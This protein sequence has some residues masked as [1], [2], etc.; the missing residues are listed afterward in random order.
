MS[1]AERRRFQRIPFVT[2]VTLYHDKEH[3]PVELVDLSLKGAL[4]RVLGET[5]LS[6]GDS[7][8]LH[9]VLSSDVI[10]EMQG[11]IA[12]EEGDFKGMQCTELDIE[13]AGHLRRLIELNLGDAEQLERELKTLVMQNS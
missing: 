3:V 4:F 11:V 5:L 10:I 1:S 6:V 13:S 9:V 8:N 2:I 7:A 12:H